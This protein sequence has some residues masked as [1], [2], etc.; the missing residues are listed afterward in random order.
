MPSIISSKDT[1]VFAPP[2]F[3]EYLLSV[4]DKYPT[5]GL[6]T[7]NR[8]PLAHRPIRSAKQ[9]EI[10]LAEHRKVRLERSK[11]CIED[12]NEV[13]NFI[14]DELPEV[15]LTGAKADFDKFYG[16]AKDIA[17]YCDI[18]ADNFRK[19]VDSV[20]I[21]FLHFL[22]KDY[23]EYEFKPSCPSRQFLSNAKDYF[24]NIDASLMIRANQAFSNIV[25]NWVCDGETRNK[26]ERKVATIRSG[27]DVNG[28][29]SDDKLF[30]F[31]RVPIDG[32]DPLSAGVERDMRGFESL[33]VY[34]ESYASRNP[35]A[36]KEKVA[37]LFANVETNNHSSTKHV[38]FPDLS[39]TPSSSKAEQEQTTWDKTYL[40]NL[41]G[42]ED[43][44]EAII[45]TIN[46]D[47][48]SDEIQEQLFD[49]LGFEQ[50][51]LITNLLSNRDSIRKQLIREEALTQAVRN[52]VKN[53]RSTQSHPVIGVKVQS[54]E[55]KFLEKVYRKEEKKA[56]KG[57]TTIGDL[58]PQAELKVGESMLAK[59]QTHNNSQ[60]ARASSDSTAIGIELAGGDLPNVYDSYAEAKQKSGFISGVKIVL[61]DNITRKDTKEYESVSLPAA[62]ANVPEFIA[63]RE[64]M[65]ITSLDPIAQQ[66]FRGMKTLNRIQTI[67]FET[68]YKTNENLLICA[69]TGAGKTNIALLSVLHCIFSN[70]E[71]G[72]IK[73]DQFKIVYV[74]PMKA[75][76]A[77]MTANFSKRLAPLGIQVRELTG[78][79]QL[80]KSEIMQTQMLVTTPE[81]WDV[82]TRKSTGD[83][84]LTQLV[85]LLIID[86]VHLLHG[87]RGPVVE[88]LVA[89]TLRL[90]ESSQR[91]IRIVG[92]SATLPNYRDVAQ[93]LRVNPRVGL[94]YFDSRFRPVPLGQTFI[95]VK[96]LSILEQHRQMDVCCYDTVLDMVR[97]G[98]QVMVFVHARNA[99]VK[100]AEVLIEQAIKSGQIEV[101]KVKSGDESYSEYGKAL[102]S[103][104]KSRNKK[105]AEL[106]SNGF[107]IHHAGMLR[108]DR[109][110]VEKLF[111]DGLVRVLCCTATLAWGV[112]L[113]AHAVVIKGTEIYDASKGSFV[114]LGI[115]DVLQIFGRAG[116][117]Q[118]DTE[119]HGTIITTHD[120]LA[121]YLSLLTNQFPIE[122]SFIK[123]LAD[124]LNAEVALGT[125]TNISEAVEWLTYTYLYI[126]MRRNPQLYGTQY[127]DALEDPNLTIRRRDL[128]VESARSLEAAKMIRFDERT[129]YLYSTDIGRTASHFYIK[130]DTIENFNEVVS[131]VMSPDMILMMI[132]KA[133]EFEQLKV[134]D[135]ELDEL[136]ILKREYCNLKVWGGSENV[137]GKVNILIQ[138]YIAR[139]QIRSFSLQS[140]Q[141]YVI[142]NASRI[143][144]GFFE[145]VLRE[146]IPLL[147]GRLLEF[148]KMLDQQLWTESHPLHQHKLLSYEIVEKLENKRLTIDILRDTSADEI[149]DWIFHRKMG[150][151][152]KRC[153]EEFPALD[154][155]VNIQPIT[156]NVLRISLAILGNFKWNDRLHGNVSESFW[157]W[158]EDS[159]N[160]VMYHHEYFIIT[161]RQ[162][163]RNERQDLVFT[164]PITEPLP[165]Q[166]LIR[167]VSDRFLGASDTVP[168]SFQHLILPE[169]HPPHTDLLDL[170]PLP[171]TALKQPQFEAL[172]SS[173][174]YFNP[175]QTQIFHTL[176]HTDSNCLVGA[177][178]GS[179]KTIAAEIAMFRV[180]NINPGRKVVYIAPLKA[181][182]RE[183]MKDWTERLG[184]RLKKK[185]VELTG[186]VTPDVRAILESDVIVTTPEKWDGI[187]RSWQ[188][189][190]YVQDVS[191]IIIDEIHLLG[192]D[193]GPVLEVIVSR[194]NYISRHTQ[195]GLRVIGL[196]TALANA[197]DLADWLGIKG[198]VGLYNFRPSV[199]PVPIQV[200]I[201][202]F[203]GKHYCPRMATMNKPTFQSIKE[204]SPCK[205]TLVFVSSRRQTRL[206]ALDLIAYLAAEGNPKQ[207]LHLGDGEMDLIISGIKEPNLKLTLAFG[208]GI[209]HAGLQDSDRKTVEELFVNQKI[210][211]LIATATL[212]WGVNFPAHLV[213]I[214]GTE[215]YDGKS[216]RYVDMPIT[217][218]LQ[219]MGR[220]GRPQF[221]NHGVAVV[222]VHDQKKNF[223]KKFLYEPFPVES[224]LLQ[225]LPDHL[226][227][228]VVA[229]TISSTQE[230]VD[231]LTYTYFFRRL[232]QNPSYYDLDSSE[233]VHINKYL[234]NL[235]S[236]AFGVLESATCIYVHEDLR[237]V[238]P[239]S[240]GRIAAY[241]Y[242]SHQTM[243]L[244]RD[245]LSSTLSL[246]DLLFV[247]TDAYEYD[248]LPVRHNEDLLNEEL[249]KDCP[250]E[251]AAGT[252]NSPH[253]K[254]HLLLQCHF[255]RLQLPCSDYYTDLKSVLD[256]AIRILQ[257]MIDACAEN[258]WLVPTLHCITIIQMIV[259]ARWLEDE[260]FMS[261]PYVDE[262][263]ANEIIHKYKCNQLP[264]LQLK[265]KDSTENLYKCLSFLETHQ[266]ETVCKV[267]NEL[268]EISLGVS[269]QFDG[270]CI[271]V[272]LSRNGRREYLDL[273]PNKEIVILLSITR[274]NQPPRDMKV[275]APKFSKPKDE[276]WF[277]VL[278][279]V[280]YRD[281][282]A[283]KRLGGVRKK[284]QQQL[285]IT[286]PKT[287]GRKIY[288]GYLI[289]DAYLGLDQQY[290]FC[291]NITHKAVSSAPPGFFADK[292]LD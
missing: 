50:V 111:S 15:K 159:V 156:R 53:S 265:T 189:R 245:R 135:E 204:H 216:H 249:A 282:I 137:H 104:E 283:L 45:V 47:K 177:P 284:A 130:Y 63:R 95:G 99:T 243:Q 96:A 133:S 158:V 103:L 55:E 244:F 152:V 97:K 109:N 87:D 100:T 68:A 120:K 148:S 222:L 219:M 260:P 89:R 209:H 26:W 272:P 57:G 51:E 228:E 9:H 233:T 125:V 37:Q 253:T 12:W 200:H 132:C 6:P 112:N 163:I 72:T 114:D 144:R 46:S 65:P 147:A 92:L 43:I 196:S 94:F 266:F 212:A 229:G 131:P 252:Y 162:V 261:L 193:R 256:Q 31:G 226:N 23:D 259:Q 172:Y 22:L 121:H 42:N 13:K 81:K 70:M 40:L 267:L 242:L 145:M 36:E 1:G 287:E 115:L 4:A 62:K 166:Y 231:Y 66:V 142:T 246:H 178:T 161:K 59:I 251:V 281:V 210:Q 30:P 33:Q 278:G 118:F 84:A 195:R 208:I 224:Q 236:K 71:G 190:S 39:P 149:G 230:A 183:R 292:D 207:W 5:L 19:K 119:G 75:L 217:D 181:L 73:K 54:A 227:A 101:F 168:V 198:F 20:A 221:D 76:A 289:S 206:T 64:L 28:D 197:R 220:A 171:V 113:P 277:M 276:G 10:D 202:G 140:D 273:P 214:K 264:L 241:Y 170:D 205:P 180:F 268:P 237:S 86:E 25:S 83:V 24:G 175:I 254:A 263:A 173:F 286:T 232:L 150:A 250:I 134:R 288:T 108:S 35:A 117:P 74:A 105:L 107:C 167:I 274:H 187:S 126:R 60:M 21:V 34:G 235:I 154:V 106:F 102:K 38:S 77:E 211:V 110:I 90:V 218:V 3:A 124:N 169:Q 61:P 182:V 153:A 122:S 32:I 234:S 192:E 201:Q 116:R 88:S 225:V 157:I 48:S 184:R 91:M 14:L 240:F 258:G 69:P 138:T 146:N 98:H 11:Q 262:M 247:M 271:E 179:G 291:F 199:R 93:F 56:L 185:V 194:T 255:S 248:Q 85:K 280:E 17:M 128:V 29:V 44:L 129:E 160:N 123:F 82:V 52:Q 213:V 186:D 49:L 176:Y 16:I 290:E 18:P 80:S 164:I 7:S 143:C 257:A 58:I 275:F 27:E 78:D 269:V 215:F 141:Q 238:E 203:P 174:S 127:L 139:G 67:V 155:N 165:P 8:N 136:D 223:Y 191:L 239:T 41:I 79:M 2:R 188:T 279:D 285:L 151:T 270:R